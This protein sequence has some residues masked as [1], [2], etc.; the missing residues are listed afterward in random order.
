MVRGKRKP[1]TG[2]RKPGDLRIIAGQHRGRKISFPD[3]PGLRP[4]GD[5]IRETLFNWLQ[6]E[7]PNADCLDL[8]AGSGALGLEAASRGAAH[9][10]LVESA[11]LVFKFL[12]QNVEVLKLDDSV[13]LIQLSAQDFLTANSRPYR[14][15]FLDP[16]FSENLYEP[17]LQQLA[18]AD[19]LTDSARIY[20]E[21]PKGF[22]L[23][24]LIPQAWELLK[25]NSAGEVDF[26]LYA[27]GRVQD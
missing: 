16:P 27:A 26:R 14:V 2:R 25:Q 8:F 12:R 23:T 24:E 6:A 18:N 21:C 20:I 10:T 15:V 7:I 13:A 19:W 5:R 17:I 3:S 1:A 9:V 22:A 4:T 11:A